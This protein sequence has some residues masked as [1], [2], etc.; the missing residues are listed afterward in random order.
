MHRYIGLLCVQEVA[1]DRYSVATAILI[2]NSD[3]VTLP[4]PKETT[5]II[6]PLPESIKC[7]LLSR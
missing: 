1:Q 3:I 2:L 5:Y 7:R 6:R 4:P